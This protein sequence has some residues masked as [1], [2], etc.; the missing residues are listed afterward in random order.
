M[1]GAI[2]RLIRSAVVTALAAW[3]AAFQNDARYLAL[4]PV[5][6]GTFKWLRDKFPDNAF[7]EYFPF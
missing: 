6:Q 4:V 2:L 7:L 3:W 5:I 1:S